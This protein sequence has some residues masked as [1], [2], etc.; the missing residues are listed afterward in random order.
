MDS[1]LRVKLPAYVISYAINA[2]LPASEAGE[3]VGAF[4]TLPASAGK[5]PYVTT[6]ILQAANLG[7]RWAWADSLRYVWLATIPFGV[8]A[9][10]CAACVP[11]IRKWETNRI[12]AQM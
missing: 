1:K 11:S 2:G 4:L 7:S 8:L 10:I 6:D 12:R 3:F 5:L 9:I